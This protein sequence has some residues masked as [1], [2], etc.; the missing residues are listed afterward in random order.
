VKGITLLYRES[1][2]S[3]AH[4]N[5]S[6]L[7]RDIVS[8]IKLPEVSVGL[9]HERDILDGL[10]KTAIA[11][12]DVPVDYRH[13]QTDMLQQLKVNTG[14]DLELYEAFETAIKE[15]MDEAKLKRNCLN[16]KR[17]LRSQLGESKIGDFISKASYKWKFER[18]KIP[19][20]KKFVAEVVSQLEPY[21]IDT[22]NKDPAVISS[23]NMKD[24]EGVRSIYTKISEQAEGKG[25]LRTGFQGINRMLDGGFRRGEQWVF[26]ALQ[27]NYKTGFSL[28]TFRQVAMYNEPV[29][30]V[31]TKRPLLLR[32]S[33]EDSLLL[34]FQALY[35]Q[36]WQNEHG[37][38]PNLVGLSVDHLAEYSQRKMAVMGYETHFMHVNPSLWSYRDICNQV[39]AFEAEG[40]EIHM[41]MVDYLLKVPTTG[42]DIGPAGHDIR[43]MYE[44]LRNFMESKGITFITPHQ[45]STDAKMLKRQGSLELVKQVEGGGFYAGSKQIDQVVDGEI[46]MNIE[47]VNNESFLTMQRGKHRKIGQTPREHLYVV[48][49]F[50]K[51]GC[52]LDDINGPDSTRKKVGGG[53]I[54]SGQETPFWEFEGIPK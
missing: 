22:D 10:K 5:S 30:T 26:G 41:V 16:M 12:C 33:F 36:L 47:T 43:N 13:E 23:V 20:V 45:L 35:S 48:L 7:V 34:N 42:C 11:M 18:E 17:S 52:I 3:G 21:Q 25:I 19:D 14:D 2:L 50:T 27:H 49:P 53:P 4:E 24:T 40:Y 8:S 9:D 29:L 6:Q 15:D 54:G 39:L 46:F 31:G 37:E 38:I 1:Q 28:T 32:I 51:G 44:R